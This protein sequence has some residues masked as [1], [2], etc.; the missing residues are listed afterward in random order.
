MPA[1]E[2]EPSTS[3]LLAPDP[4]CGSFVALLSKQKWLTQAKL[5]IQ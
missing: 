3:Y 2:I 5:E 1:V 4:L